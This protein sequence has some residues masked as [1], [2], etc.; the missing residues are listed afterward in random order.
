MHFKRLYVSPTEHA[1]AMLMHKRAPTKQCCR[2]VY[3]TSAA[4]HTVASAR[5]LTMCILTDGV[6]NT[7]LHSS[8]TTIDRELQ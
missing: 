2:I 6:V 1:A 3:H 4:E 5:D 7:P 8:S